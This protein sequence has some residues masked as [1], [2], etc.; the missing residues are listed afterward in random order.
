MFSLNKYS[1]FLCLIGFF[2]TAYLIMLPHINTIDMQIEKG[3]DIIY[4]PSHV[5]GEA[6]QFDNHVKLLPSAQ[7]SRFGRITGKLGNIEHGQSLYPN[8]LQ[9]I[10]VAFMYA[11]IIAISDDMDTPYYALPFFV[12][13]IYLTS[14]YLIR[15]FGADL[16]TAL[17]FP[18]IMIFGYHFFLFDLFFIPN[19]MLHP[20]DIFTASSRIDPWVESQEYDLNSFY[21]I[22]TLGA[23][24]IFFLGYIYFFYKSLIDSA[25]AKKYMLPMAIIL[26]LQFYTYVFYAMAAGISFLLAVLWMFIIAK[27]K[28]DSGN[29]S[30]HVKYI[31]YSGLI[32]FFLALP[33]LIQIISLTTSI[34]NSDWLMRVG[35]NKAVDTVF[36]ANNLM[37]GL[38]VFFVILSQNKQTRIT[39]ISLLLTVLLVENS[40]VLIGLDIQPGHISMRAVMPS[41]ILFSGCTLYFQSLKISNMLS[42]YSTFPL[43]LYAYRVLVTFIACYFAVIAYNYSQSYAENTYKHQGISASQD[44]L[45]HW[46]KK[47]PNSNVATLLPSIGVPIIFKSPSYLYLTFSGHLHQSV[48]NLDI[49]KRLVNVLWLF[50]ADN[51]QIKDYFNQEQGK[52]FDKRYHY[53]YWQRR[54]G[55]PLAVTGFSNHLSFL[56]DMIKNYDV[57]GNGALC[58]SS[59]DYL[60]VDKLNPRQKVFSGVKLS[61]LTEVASF[62]ELVVY[63][64]NIEDLGCLLT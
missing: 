46:L 10:I 62:D 52:S 53:Y 49:D 17:M 21:R 22:H 50:G 1:I 18:I 2:L 38:L 32:A 47:R 9:E 25:S 56:S 31:F 35:A 12:G 59:F 20:E 63:K 16:V 55:Y 40:S 51:D 26:A 37:Y 43:F 23:S 39:S 60:V 61:Y 19:G 14:F 29:A 4:T 44:A 6:T 30:Q 45:H 64:L 42:K 28:T 11:P 36:W 27:H 33:S 41:I 3:V 24:Y 48:T 15:M 57:N 8:V 34:E 58:Q 5:N 13:L 54:F 7:L